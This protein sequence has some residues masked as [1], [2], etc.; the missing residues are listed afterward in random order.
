MIVEI[1][2]IPDEGQRLKG[3]EPVEILDLPPNAPVR[4]EGPI[5]YDFT[6]EHLGGE[7][8]VR[9]R[10]AA[11]AVYACAR[12][13]RPCTTEVEDPGFACSYDLQEGPVPW[14]EK[15]ESVDLTPDIREATILTL[16]AY[17]VCRPECLGL[18]PRC[19]A[20]LNKGRC[21]CKPVQDFRWDILDKLK[22]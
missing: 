14:A 4:V 7:L 3:V 16:P 9:G 6:V 15:G 19:G 10:L 2:K 5:R 21:N 13:N 20:D 11:R 8:I 12:C 18:C 1:A 17:P 22:S